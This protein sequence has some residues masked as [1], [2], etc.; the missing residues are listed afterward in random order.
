V[1]TVGAVWINVLPSMQG[2]ASNL[3]KQAT[4]AAKVAAAGAGTSMGTA[5]ADSTAG[6]MSR[7]MTANSRRMQA[8]F[9]GSTN[10][11][12][13]AV[14]N[15]TAGFKAADAAA[16]AF[17]G[18][19]GS[20]GG[21]T[22]RAVAPAAQSV[23]RFRDGF[24]S[25]AAA[26]S[27]FSG[28]MGTLG[29]IAGRTLTPAVQAVGRFKDGFTNSAAAAS[30]FSG[31]LGTLGGVVRTAV[32]PGVTAVR[33]V[34]TGLTTAGATAGK[35]FGAIQSGAGTAFSAVRSAGASAFSR[36]RSGIASLTQGASQASSGIGGIGASLRSL[37]AI[38]ATAL[39]A[40]GIGQFVSGVFNTSTAIN[41]ARASLTGMYGD[42]EQANAM[43]ASINDE[44]SRSSVGVGVLNSLAANLAYMGFEGE[45]ATNMIRN[46]DTAAGALPGNA[47][48]AVESVSNAL[49]TSQVQGNAF[50]GELNQISRVG[51]PI[52]DALAQHLN[53]SSGEIKKMASEGKISFEDL[54]HVMNDPSMSKFW[55][56]TENSAKGV[57]A[58]FR[59]TFTGIV[60]MVQ[61][62][63]AELVETGLNRLAPGLGR[64]GDAVES[65]LDSLPGVM[66]RIGSTLRGAG[67]IDGFMN[68][69]QGAKEFGA[70][71]LPALRSF[72][73]VIGTAFVGALKVMGPVGDLLKSMAGWMRENEGV[74]RVLG[75]ALGGAVV[76]MVA[77]RAATM[78]WA[79]AQA[80]LN[81]ALS[82]NPIGL[83]VIA[84]AALVAGVIY[85]YKNFEGFRTVVDTVASAIKTAAVWIWDNGLKPAFDGIVAGAKWVGQA[86]MWLWTNALKPAWDGIVAGAKTV[87]EWALWLWESAIKPAFGFIDGAARTLVTA[88]LTGLIAPTVI[89]FKL[90]AAAA[91]WLWT[92]AIKPAFGFIA[93]IAVWLWTTVI[94]PVFNLWMSYIRNVLAP[95]V[96]WLW[97]SIIK[98]AF[99]FIASYISFVWNSQ[100]KPVWNLLRT[101]VIGTLATVFK[102]LWNSVIKPVW[103]GIQATIRTAWNI[104]KGIWSA[105]RTYIIGPLGS[106]FRW[107]WNNVIKPVWSGI[108]STINSVWNNGIKPA[109][110]KVREGVRAMR[111]AFNNGK[112]A[113]GK[114][115]K[116]IRDSAKTPVNFL[117]GTVYNDGIRAVWNKVAGIVGADK[118]GKVKEFASGGVLPG[119]S[120]GRDIH[121][122]YSPTGGALALSGGEAIMRPEVTR[123]LGTSG[124][125]RINA[126]A[127]SGGVSGVR[128]AL[129]FARGGV[130]GAPKRFAKGGWLGVRDI[131]PDASGFLGKVA[132]FIKD[133]AVDVFTGDL[134]SAVDKVFK[135]AKELTGKFGKTGFPGAPYQMVGKFNKSLKEKIESFASFFMDE[136]FSLSGVKGEARNVLKVARAAVGKYPESGGNNTNAITRWYGMNGQPWCFPAGTLVR[137]PDGYLP[138]EQVEPGT[139]VVTPSGKTARTSALLKRVK[140][141][142]EL[143]AFGVAPMSPTA[144]HPYW[145]RRGKHGAPEWIKAGGLQRGD[146]IAVPLTEGENRP[147]DVD[148]AHLLGVYVADGH[149]LHRDRG[150]QI[151]DSSDQVERLVA[152]VKA[153]G[154]E[155][156]VTY[157]RTSAAVT[158]YDAELYEL[159]GQAGDLAHGKRV[160][161]LVLNADADAREAFLR[162]YLGGDGH[163]DGRGVWQCTTVS[164]ELAVS[165]SELL[166][167]LGHIP[168]VRVVREAGEMVIEGRTVATRRAFAVTF[169]PE[170][171][172]SRASWYI[173]DGV[174]WVPVRSVEETGRVEEV[175]DLTVPG[176][177]AFIADGV[178]VHNCAM[179][180]S[181][182]FA[183]AN[184]S[185]SLG[186][187]AKV[188][189]VDQYR[190]AM[191]NV[192]QAN[193]QPGDVLVYGSRHVNLAT[194]KYGTIGGNE[195]NNVRMSSRYY[196]TP[197]YVYRPRWK[198]SAKVEGRGG[199]A[200][201]ARGGT[202]SAPLI[203]KIA[204]QD[205]GDTKTPIMRALYDSGGY[206]QPGTTLVS[207]RSGRP[208]PVLTSAQ[209]RDMH[210]I[211]ESAAGRD[212]GELMRDAHVHLYESEATVREAF[213]EIDLEL[214]KR[215]RGGVHAGRGA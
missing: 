19:M 84:I 116:G 208:E 173:E 167:S 47:A 95:V 81:V 155:P 6:A 215:R 73:T 180:I 172:H 105:L 103:A 107:L 117:I 68:L 61:V 213:R 123:A 206:V 136:G 25:A 63:T 87:G 134:G 7:R 48:A 176:E 45:K 90:L 65:G 101:Y 52:F 177:H 70:A 130:W 125:E 69:V 189:H 30:A 34:G 138:I 150:V 80:I 12:T 24:R 72:G 192:G 182:L 11:M 141:V 183:K 207:N 85:A 32:Q 16:S 29:G 82:A 76:A 187:A 113:I 14:A 28:R 131:A 209:W 159:C 169:Q 91:M 36:V 41:E 96:M 99:G 38:G 42:A 184:A 53:K 18:R 8:T 127:R 109:F 154:W 201:F 185:G 190:G 161:G 37:G 202:M 97:N 79:A 2:F 54:M 193:R 44:F 59:S 188:A 51:F 143:K 120:P 27:A 132:K 92:N 121:M 3:Q 13:R 62:K 147:V 93:D 156:H 149:R 195:G 114:A 98:P 204:R 163:L 111:D 145:A 115:W 112:E 119:Y 4:S 77:I 174:L 60:S 64:L 175:Y 74:V 22:S 157:G 26:A 67:I 58:T 86:A 124:V 83:I 9:V 102:W 33:A 46:I 170:A 71:A 40:I 199:D 191:K 212:G 55:E 133:I 144:D 151:S 57:S 135:P 197:T 17:T 31:R 56:M 122:F 153:A 194:S 181:W 5:M 158:V 75:A 89:A 165:L 104:I 200:T 166:R 21:V 139:P 66:S 171:T 1:A 43:V 78:A 196:E 126:A 129:G 118:I 152:A 140:P 23:G 148:V 39:G 186:R 108:S 211:A 164:R 210:R 35:A 137:T 205:P 160:P 128:D 50:V 198:P 203:R 214:R 20:L 100:I 49:L 88:L 94:Q 142:L 10:M 146:M 162:G 168:S 110:A 15:F 179:F 106:V 178:H